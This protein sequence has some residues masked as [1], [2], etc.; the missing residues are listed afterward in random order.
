MAALMSLLLRPRAGFLM[1]SQTPAILTSRPASKKSGGSSKNLGGKSPGHRYGFKKQDG[2]FVR[3][4]N[5]LATQRLMRWHP[6]AHVG[7]GTN[8]TLYALEDG[9]VR[10]TK[11]LYVPL[12]R[13]TEARDLIPKLPRGA[14]LYK[15]FVN[16]VPTKQENNFKLV[17]MV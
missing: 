12:P 17:D 4:G 15:S 5:I 8:N 13:S 11:E 6:G 10:F 3:A 14:V 7:I 1:S 16:V 2:D 9:T